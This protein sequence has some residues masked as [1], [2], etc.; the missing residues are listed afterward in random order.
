MVEKK[1]L[2]VDAKSKFQLDIF[3]LD[4]PIQFRSI[5][6]PLSQQFDGTHILRLRQG[7]LEAVA[8]NNHSKHNM[9]V[10]FF[11]LQSCKNS[12]CILGTC[13]SHKYAI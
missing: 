10:P 4:S 1:R 2:K 9:V 8:F 13:P 12:F 6:G 3:V 11:S 7:L 5:D